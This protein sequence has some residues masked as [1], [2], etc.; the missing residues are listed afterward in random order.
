[1]LDGVF[2]RLRGTQ[3]AFITLIT[4]LPGIPLH[5]GTRHVPSLDQPRVSLGSLASPPN[6]FLVFISYPALHSDPA[7]PARVVSLLYSA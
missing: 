6:A 5:I 2:P 7:E 4:Q 3:L 1:M